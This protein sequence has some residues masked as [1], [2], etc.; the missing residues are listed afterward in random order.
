MAA[1]DR[2]I[3]DN[4]YSPARGFWTRA[5]V[6]EVLPDPPSPLGWDLVFEGGTILGWRDCM[7]NRLGI[8]DEEVDRIR[9]EVMGVFGGY[10]YLGITILRV[11]AVRTPGFTPEALDAAY[12][13][14]HPGIPP[15]E[16]EP[17]HE[18][19]ATTEKMGGWLGWV[20]GDRDQ[21]E[22]EADRLA[23]RAVRAA[24]PDLAAT[25]DA[26]LLALATALKPM[27]RSLFDQHINQ[28]GAASIAPGVI[29]AVCAAVGR[30]TDTMR[31]LAGLGGVDS[32]APS[33]AM[34]E[35][36][37]VVRASAALT[38]HFDAGIDR[39]HDRL[40]ADAA[41]ADVAVF[42]ATLDETLAK[43]STL[44]DDMLSLWQG[45]WKG[46]IDAVFDDYQY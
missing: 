45:R 40:R 10:A 32:A 21:S 2:W 1:V 35:L 36:S 8:L 39:L 42:L 34:W 27:I 28:S 4:V 22:L 16:A 41:A 13:A 14:G 12:F 3:D 46:N 5:N 18:N 6:G 15:Y 24:R 30:P 31:L 44:A 38:A 37:R 29:G 25:S 20:M 26:D 11:W 19:M 7:V 9:P 43:R 23:A 17:W 33:S